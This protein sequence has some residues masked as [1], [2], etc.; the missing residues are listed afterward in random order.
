MP[1]AGPEVEGR[2]YGPG[3]RLPGIPIARKWPAVD[4]PARIDGPSGCLEL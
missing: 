4:G 3:L 2:L 1:T